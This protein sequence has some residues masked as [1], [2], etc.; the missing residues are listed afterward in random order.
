VGEGVGRGEAGQDSDPTSAHPYS[1]NVIEAWNSRKFA[2]RG[3]SAVP[4]G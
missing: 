1:P 2:A 4:T 3:R